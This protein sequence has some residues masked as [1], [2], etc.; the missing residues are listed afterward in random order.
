MVFS[1]LTFLHLFLPLVLLAY[2][3]ALAVQTR[4][5]I[6]STLPLNAVL[7][8]SS[9]VFYAWDEGAR[10]ALLF[11][12]SGISFTAGW[13]LGRTHDARARGWILALALSSDL[14]LLFYFKYAP[15][16][17]GTLPD[18]ETARQLQ[19]WTAGIL[20]PLGISFFTFQTMSYV[21][22]VYR[23]EVAPCRNPL[24]FLMYIAFF[25]HLVAGPIVRYQ[26]LETEL[27]ARRSSLAQFASG[28]R[29][30]ILGLGKKVLIANVLSVPAD[31]AF[32]DPSQLPVDVAW[33]GLVAYTLQLYFDFSGYSDMAI[34]LARMFG[35]E[36]PENFRAP[37]SATSVTDF[38]RRWHMSLSTW[39]RD[40]LYIPL[41]GNRHGQLRTLLNL[42][43]VFALCGLWH[44]AN[45]T[46]LAWGLYHGGFLILE[47]LVSRDTATPRPFWGRVWTL[48]IVMG[49]WLLFRS[50]TLLDVGTYAL[51]LIGSAASTS[52]AGG[53]LLDVPVLLALTAGVLLCLPR[54]EEALRSGHWTWPERMTWANVASTA[55]Y[56][57]VFAVSVNCLLASLNN[58]FIY[59]RF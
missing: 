29:R 43:I 1:S 14:A 47:R 4:L 59:F 15:F 54:V 56:A 28:V 30:F 46:F 38:W 22:D 55:A 42:L 53:N 52:P 7:L 5:G 45:W 16:V 32:S 49:G 6:R 19:A 20:L 39:F 12:S 3:A 41:G 26:L 17:A 50:S 33:L 10:C 8:A 2:Y 13:L 23:G 34:G 37:Y 57:V 18:S 48:P 9:L 40:Y 21:I 24:N 25:A 58:P 27:V 11:L 31:R 51:A 36:F 35:F 44:G